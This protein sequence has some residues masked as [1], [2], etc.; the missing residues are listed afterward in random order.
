MT[1]RLSLANHGDQ[2]LIIQLVEGAAAWLRSKE[3][4]QWARPW[5]SRTERDERIRK[6]VWAGRTWIAWDGG[7]AAATITAEP[8][9]DQ[10]LWADWD[11]DP[12]TY[13]RR[14]V[15]SRSYAGLGLGSSLLDWAGRE[16][17]W[18]YGAQWIRLDVWTTNKVLHRYYTQLGFAFL[19]F[20]RDP[21]YPSGAL[22][23]KATRLIPAVD[24]RGLVE[25]D[26]H[27]FLAARDERD[28][29]VPLPRSHIAQSNCLH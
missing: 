24:G 26:P 12:A 15:V 20:C 28:I 4:D 7:V 14:L 16:A 19:G 27:S 25:P 29:R 3:T 22:F 6:D 10:V 8:A 23:Q 5:P 21:G 13:V 1:F 11:S 17:E 2:N 18:H 9:P